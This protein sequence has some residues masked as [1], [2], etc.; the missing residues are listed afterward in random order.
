MFCQV[1]LPFYRFPA[2]LQNKGEYATQNVVILSAHLKR[3]FLLWS[4]VQYKRL[5]NLIL[6]YPPLF[7]GTTL[8][9]CLV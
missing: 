4:E 3:G 6:K 9:K 5:K 2:I 8:R 1:Q 7:L